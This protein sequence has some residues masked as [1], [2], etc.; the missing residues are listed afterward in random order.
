MIQ[1]QLFHLGRYQAKAVA[2]TLIEAIKTSYANEHDLRY[3]LFVY[4]SRF[5]CSIEMCE[6]MPLLLTFNTLIV[7]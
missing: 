4:D 3:A 5:T 2:Q 6:G 7:L 1:R